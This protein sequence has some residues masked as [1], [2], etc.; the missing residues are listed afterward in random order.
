MLSDA[1]RRK[2]YDASLADAASAPQGRRPALIA[3]VGAGIG[4]S[5]LMDGGSGDQRSDTVAI[6]TS[7]RPTQPATTTTPKPGAG[8]PTSARSR[9]PTPAGPTATASPVIVATTT[10]IDGETPAVELVASSGLWAVYD[11]A[12]RY[13]LAEADLYE[14]DP[15]LNPYAMYPGVT[16]VL[17]PCAS[18]TECPETGGQ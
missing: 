9:S 17:I 14:C 11:I 18:E 5:A 2:A 13:G 16:V 12:N 4:A 1:A 10:C 8:T 3:G 15:Y 6:I 7:P